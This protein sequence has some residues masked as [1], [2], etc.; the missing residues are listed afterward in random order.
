MDLS[1]IIDHLDNFVTT[2]EGWSAVFKGINGILGLDTE[3]AFEGVS[4]KFE[5]LSSTSST[6]SEA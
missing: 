1:T 6:T 2:W 3:T 5:V 4:S